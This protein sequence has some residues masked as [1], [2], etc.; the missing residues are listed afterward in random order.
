MNRTKKIIGLTAT[1]G[2]L[3]C[4]SV[5]GTL[6]YLTDEE[7]VTNTFT[8]GD[9]DITLD[10]SKVGTDGVII[11]DDRVDGNTYHLIPGKEYV[12]DPIVHVTEGSENCYVF[13]KVENGL[14]DIIDDNYELKDQMEKN[15]WYLVDGKTNIYQYNLVVSGSDDLEVFEKLVI[16]E[17][18]DVSGCEEDK[19]IITACA[20]QAEGFAAEDNVSEALPEDFL[21]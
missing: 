16:A 6:A 13:V 14:E 10:E 7:V 12:K 9:I 18:A 5:M 17:H 19:I 21:K 15:G 11:G 1:V 2:A 3:V 4:V 8:V 20:I